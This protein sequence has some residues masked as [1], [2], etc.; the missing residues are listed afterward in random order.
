MNA[1][2]DIHFLPGNTKKKNIV[3]YRPPLR[4]YRFRVNPEAGLFPVRGAL[5]EII[6]QT[7]DVVLAL[8]HLED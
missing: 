2:I 8:I 6:C 1:G 4:S 7:A 5:D 3:L